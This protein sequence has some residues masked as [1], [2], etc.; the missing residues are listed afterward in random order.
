MLNQRAFLCEF[1]SGKGKESWQKMRGKL[2]KENVPDRIKT[3]K[4]R[5]VQENGEAEVYSRV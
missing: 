2:Q 4:G 3:E 5:Q 1:F